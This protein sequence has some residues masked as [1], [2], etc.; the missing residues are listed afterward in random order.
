M[1]DSE[2]YES[3]LGTRYAGPEMQRIYSP[4]H[5]ARL[6]RRLWHLLAREQSALGLDISDA[7]LKELEENI[8]TVDLEKVAEYERVTRHDVMAHI[9]AYG[10]QCP[11]AK[12][13]IHL[14][15]TSCYVTDNADQLILHQGMGIIRNKL[16]LLLRH[17]ANSAREHAALPCLAYTHYQAAQPT[18]VG[19]RICLW[20]QDFLFDHRDLSYRMDNFQLLGAKGATGTQAS[21]LSLFGG[22][23]DR[24]EELD[25]NIVQALGFGDPLPISGQTY[26]R[27]IDAHVLDTL[28]GIATSAHKMCTDLRLLA[29]HGEFCEPWNETKEGGQ[30]GS[31]AMPYKQNPMLSERCCS[32]SRF[33][34]SLSENAR[35]TAALQWFERTL[36]DSANRRLSLPEAFLATDGLLNLCVHITKGWHFHP[37]II[38]RNLNEQLPFMA[39]EEILMRAVRFGADRQVI[40]ERLR[41]HSRAAG[42]RIRT[43]GTKN[44]L[45]QR[46][47]RDKEIPLDASALQQCLDVSRFVARCPK[48]VEEFLYRHVGPAITSNTDYSLDINIQV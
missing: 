17:L 22:D 40:H 44:D 19:K 10:D 20:L 15:A 5:R 14:G 42:E 31:S 2:H 41:Q 26:P 38:A 45:L 28:A 25:Y 34:L 12:G 3:P 39:T 37:A 18:T 7:Q 6:W 27:K 11:S 48:Q 46:I 21:F 36:D 23:S 32:L 13:I 47:A 30:V 24:V 33:V 8:D 1:A 35:Y 29:N 9:H 4:Q 43:E 16:N